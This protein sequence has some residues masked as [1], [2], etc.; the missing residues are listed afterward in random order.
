M[1]HHTCMSS[2]L[3]NHDPYQAQADAQA[4]KDAKLNAAI[5]DYFADHLDAY[6]SALFMV[7]TVLSN[8][9]KSPTNGVSEHRALMEI[10][11]TVCNYVRTDDPMS[12]PLVR[13]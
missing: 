10:Y 13:R 1:I 2:H 9:I 12:L 6:P 11:N 3:P 4:E 5:V 8:A 7:A